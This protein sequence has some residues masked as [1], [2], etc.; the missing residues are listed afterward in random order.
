MEAPIYTRAKARRSVIATAA[1][2]ALSQVATVLGYIV[3]VR[4]MPEQQ[5]GVYSLLYSFLPV[6]GTVLSLGLEQVLQRYQPEYLRAGNRAGA[7]WLMRTIART[8]LL[9]NIVMLVVVLLSW[10]WIAPLFKLAPYRGMFALFG[11]L[12]LMHFQS[13]ILQIAL[14]SHMMHRFSVGAMTML[15]IVK[16]IGYGVLFALHRLQLETA[17]LADMIAYACAYTAMRIVYRRQCITAEANLPYASAAD[18]RKRL[19]RYGL[20]NN[21]NDAGVFLLYSTLDNFFIAAYLDTLSV[22]IYSFYS[23][24][25]QMLINSLPPKL[26]SNVVQ[27]MFFAIAPDQAD[28]NI[29]RYF[30]FLLNL[31]LLLMWPALAFAVVYHTEIVYAVF[32]GKFVAYSWLLPIFIGFSLLNIVAD[33]ATLVAQ[34]EEKVGILLLSKVFAAYNILAM[35]LLVP[36]F[37]VYGAAVAGGSAQALKNAFI[38]WH[39]RR[40]AVWVNGRASLLSSIAIWGTA[41]AAGY[42]LKS[43]VHVRPLLELAMGAGVFAAA[44]LVYVRSPTLSDSDRD[45]LRSVIPDKAAPVLRA[46]GLLRA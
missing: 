18:E 25:R 42:G 4:G 34:Y 16:S 8:R 19:L 15:A 9:A 14:G 24:L 33:P 44:A 1:F 20:Y 30:S 5:F 27:P 10:N 31:N 40:R 36:F 21:F 11:L 6:V 13:S 43:V 22:G 2:R 26:F 17:I 32:A 38:W 7:A 12:I 45:I 41:V 46:I 23:R 29:P 35:F 3:L 28:R 39:V 37:G